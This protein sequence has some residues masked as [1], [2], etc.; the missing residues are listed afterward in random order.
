MNLDFNSTASLVIAD[1]I[2]F[3]QA[4]EKH[5]CL[6]DK[7][8]ANYDKMKKRAAAKSAVCTAMGLTVDSKVNQK[9]D[10]MLGYARRNLLKGPPSKGSVS[11]N[12]RQS[13]KW[14][15]L[16]RASAFLRNPQMEK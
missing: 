14:K 9:F 13:K 6:Y 7:K 8:N 16:Q 10:N 5:P 15:E 3:F 1:Y 4:L 2:K 12:K 11:P